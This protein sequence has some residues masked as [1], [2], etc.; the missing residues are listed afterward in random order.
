MFRELV[1]MSVLFVFPKCAIAPRKLD[2]F[3]FNVVFPNELIPKPL[4]SPPF[5]S[6]SMAGIVW[7]RFVGRRDDI[8]AVFGVKLPRARLFSGQ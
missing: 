5:E 1:V 4:F 2:I 8:L 6:A 7:L 3:V